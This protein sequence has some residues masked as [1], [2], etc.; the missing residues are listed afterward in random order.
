VVR[1]VMRGKSCRIFVSTPRPYNSAP[2]RQDCVRSTD[3]TSCIFDP[4]VVGQPQ[5]FYR[6][7]LTNCVP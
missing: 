5:R 1:S 6:V 3:S 4:V 2:T 7:A